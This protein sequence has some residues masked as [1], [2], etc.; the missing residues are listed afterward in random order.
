M[1]ALRRSKGSPL[2][3]DVL[4]SAAS[5]GSRT[6][7]NLSLGFCSFCKRRHDRRTARTARKACRWPKL[8]NSWSHYQGT[9]SSTH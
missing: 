1:S 5:E 7:R 3:E 4:T 2:A 8:K 9:V 6:S